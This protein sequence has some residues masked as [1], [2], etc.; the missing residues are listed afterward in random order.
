MTSATL[1]KIRLLCQ[2]AGFGGNEEGAPTLPILPDACAKSPP[3][4][5]LHMGGVWLFAVVQCWFLSSADA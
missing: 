3:P 1:D 4:L 2:S 5:P